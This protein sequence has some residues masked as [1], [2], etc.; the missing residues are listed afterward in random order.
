M[1]GI[2]LAGGSSTR[3]YPL[4]KVT[5]KQFLPIYDKSMI[6]YPMSVLMNAGIWDILII[7]TPYDNLRF[8]DL[9]EDGRQFGVNLSYAVQPSSDGLA[10]VRLIQMK[11]L[12]KTDCMLWHKLISF[13]NDENRKKSRYYWENALKYGRA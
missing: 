9:L 5:S 12:D 2:I 8:Q 1:K 10:R 7:S 13:E 4:T 3:L 6:Y 11:N